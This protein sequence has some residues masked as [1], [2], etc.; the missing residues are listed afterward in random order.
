MDGVCGLYL[1]QLSQLSELQWS[2]DQGRAG[3]FKFERL[4]KEWW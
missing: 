1:R 4:V 3:R 2:Y